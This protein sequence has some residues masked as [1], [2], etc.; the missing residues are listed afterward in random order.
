MLKAK[1]IQIHISLRYAALDAMD[2][3]L[4]LLATQ[5]RRVVKTLL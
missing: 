1:Y 4:S 5:E 3:W 2:P